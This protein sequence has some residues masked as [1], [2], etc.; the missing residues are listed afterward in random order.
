MNKTFTRVFDAFRA[1][2]PDKASHSFWTD[3][4]GNIYSYETCILA[5]VN[6]NIYAVN[7]TRYSQTTSRYQNELL[8]RL[9][10]ASILDV[11]LRNP[12][13]I[14]ATELRSRSPLASSSLELV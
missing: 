14:T 10:G 8:R 13:G 12:R 1:D 5:R 9:T 7:M 4:S 2:S 11:T 6:R 3:G